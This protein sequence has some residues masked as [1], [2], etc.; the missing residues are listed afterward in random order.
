MASIDVEK[1][2]ERI[3]QAR[4][5]LREERQQLH[6]DSGI[7]DEVGEITSV[8]FNH[9][10]D[11]ATETFE[12][13]KDIALTANVDGVLA[14]VEEALGKIE[15]GTYG[16]CDRCDKE[17]PAARLEALPYA[18]LCVECQERIENTQ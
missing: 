18:T 1:M 13:S 10:G 2:K 11:S 17:I 4:E 16:V 3:L 7:S 5:H 9:P 12:R 14:Q 6:G 8:D 15:A